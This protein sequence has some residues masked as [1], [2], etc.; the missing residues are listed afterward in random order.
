LVPVFTGRFFQLGD[1][2]SLFTKPA[3]M[4]SL[5]RL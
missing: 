4:P 5:V 2:T 3:K 1:K